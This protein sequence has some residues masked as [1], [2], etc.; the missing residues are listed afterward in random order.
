M[1]RR[2][3]TAA[4]SGTR[5]D[6]NTIIRS[7]NAPATTIPMHASRRSEI[8]SVTSMSDAVCPPT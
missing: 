2:F 6:R 3:I 4:L 7:R 5:I 8:R 1:D